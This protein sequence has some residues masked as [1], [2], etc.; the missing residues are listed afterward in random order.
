[1]ASVCETPKW[2][3]I[4]GNEEVKI[5]EPMYTESKRF[6]QAARET[7]SGEYIPEKV[8]SDIQNATNPFLSLDQFLEDGL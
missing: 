1:M 3:T 7:R 8:R 4:P 6:E 5:A 2:D